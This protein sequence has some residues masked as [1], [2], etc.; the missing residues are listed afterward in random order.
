LWRIDP[1]EAVAAE[2]AAA[3]GI[4]AAAAGA[5]MHY[6]ICLH[7][8]SPKVAAL[9]TTGA[10]SYRTV[11]MIVARTLLALEPHRA[12]DRLQRI[13]AERNENQREIATR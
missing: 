3:Q 10:I 11:S 2:V 6:A 1:W 5:K 8:R 9:F 7:E 12:A 4:T 13:T